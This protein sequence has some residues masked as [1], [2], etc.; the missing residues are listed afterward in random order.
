MNKVNNNNNSSSSDEDSCGCTCN[1]S[2][3][4]NSSSNSISSERNLKEDTIERSNNNNINSTNKNA[5]SNVSLSVLEEPENEESMTFLV[6]SV[7]P[8]TI[9]GLQIQKL[10]W[11]DFKGTP[12]YDMRWSAHVYWGI[13]YTYTVRQ[14]P[15][16][17]KRVSYMILPEVCVW[18]RNRSW[19]KKQ[20]AHLLNHEQGHYLIGCFCGLEFKK[21]ALAFK[22][23]DNYRCEI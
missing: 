17:N 11:S 23:T 7:L 19:T 14:L 1:S 5:K 22:F 20:V 2:T 10:Q 9:G 8:C 21:Q 3:S 16:S 15:A 4:T 13:N 6:D 18:M 12:N